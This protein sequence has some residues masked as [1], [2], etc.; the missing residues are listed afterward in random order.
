[1][2]TSLNDAYT[3]PHVPVEPNC[4]VNIHDYQKNTDVNTDIEGWST[5][6][7]AS[8]IDPDVGSLDTQE[9]YKENFG[10]WGTDTRHM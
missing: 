2:Y 9:W 7:N 8:E 6:C 3:I 10:N 5:Q 4:I 1:M